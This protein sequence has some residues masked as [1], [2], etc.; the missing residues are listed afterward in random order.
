MSNNVKKFESYW[1][2]LVEMLIRIDSM[3]ELFVI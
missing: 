3:F 1:N 2:F